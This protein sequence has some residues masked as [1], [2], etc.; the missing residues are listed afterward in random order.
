MKKLLLF[1]AFLSFNIHASIGVLD[2]HKLMKEIG[3]I[4]YSKDDISEWARESRADIIIWGSSE[5]SQSAPCAY[6]SPQA[7]VTQ[8][9]IDWLKKKY[10]CNQCQ[11][12]CRNHK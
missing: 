6:Y 4:I 9:F 2:Y 11:L 5:T 12:H 10:I 8:N 7:D 3:T 1:C